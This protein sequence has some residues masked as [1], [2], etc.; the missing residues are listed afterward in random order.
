MHHV[1]VRRKFI[2]RCF[3]RT[4]SLLALIELQSRKDTGSRNEANP[5]RIYPKMRGTWFARFCKKRKQRQ[6]E[7]LSWQE[8]LFAEFLKGSELTDLFLGDPEI[9]SEERGD[10]IYEVMLSQFE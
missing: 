2:F 4:R 8:E 9:D 10:M 3:I 1:T 6:L 7:T 5:G